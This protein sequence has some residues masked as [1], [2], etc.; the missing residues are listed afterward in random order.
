MMPILHSPGVM[1]PGQ[2]GPIRWVPGLSLRKALAL[3][4]SRTG[5]PS[6]MA[7]MTL[8]PASAASR[9][10]SAAKGGGMK[11]MVASAPVASTASRTVLKMG[12][13]F[14]SFWPPLPGVTPP[15]IFVPYSRHCLVWNAPADPVMPWQMTLV[16]LLTRMLISWDRLRVD[17]GG[18]K[19][20][21]GKRWSNGGGS[22]EGDEETGRRVKVGRLI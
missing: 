21:L 22:D 12:R 13:P 10:P 9:M 14:A 16:F 5:M 8:M 17:G 20:G 15:T 7:Q 6:V 4:M 3:T 18:G 11:I 19:G 2:L 1:T